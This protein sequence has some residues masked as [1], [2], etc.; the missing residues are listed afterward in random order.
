[1]WCVFHL[2]KNDNTFHP[3]ISCGECL[4][5]VPLITSVKTAIK[6]SAGFFFL[7][8]LLIEF[9][10]NTAHLVHEPNS[11]PRAKP[12]MSESLNC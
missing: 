3:F 8:S 6:S 1:M 12:S 11:N 10:N 4:K 7:V 9:K 5:Q 2:L